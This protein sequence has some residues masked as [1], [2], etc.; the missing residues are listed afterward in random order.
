MREVTAKSMKLGRDLDGMLSEALER[1][2]LV[3]IGWGRGGD[4]K[5]RERGDDAVTHWLNLRL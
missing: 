5:G 4:E 3:R 2:L 1:D